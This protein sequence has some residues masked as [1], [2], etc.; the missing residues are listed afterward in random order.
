MLHSVHISEEENCKSNVMQ[1]IKR[2][3]LAVVRCLLLMFGPLADVMH[4][5]FELR[6]RE[7]LQH[8]KYES[9]DARGCT[10]MHLE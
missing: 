8:P 9:R 6:V 4:D 7:R 2:I 10:T 5:S 3:M 1:H